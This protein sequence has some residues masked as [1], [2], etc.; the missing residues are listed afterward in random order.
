MASGVKRKGVSVVL[1][2]YDVCV[3]SKMMFLTSQH[4]RTNPED[5]ISYAKFGPETET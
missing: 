2:K 4:Q 5:G 3:C 1:R